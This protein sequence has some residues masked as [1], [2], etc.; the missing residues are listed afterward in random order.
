[1]RLACLTLSAAAAAGLTS[2]GD[3]GTGTVDAGSGSQIVV[4]E[5]HRQ[6]ADGATYIEGAVQFVEVTRR[7]QS[8][9]ALKLELGRNRVV[10]TIGPGDY[11]VVSYT[12]S[13][14]A[15]CAQQL[16][17]PSDRCRRALSIKRGERRTL[18]VVTVVGRRCAIRIA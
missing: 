15:S 1:M 11:R 2:C 9:P 14:S 5:I 13:C 10:R 16:D 12:R 7:G 8:G 18:D 17:A 4:R 6:R 3:G